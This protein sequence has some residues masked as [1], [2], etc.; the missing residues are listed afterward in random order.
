MRYRR[1]DAKL[2]TVAI[3][4][5]VVV[6]MFAQSDPAGWLAPILGNATAAGILAA[7]VLYLGPRAISEWKAQHDQLI[8]GFFGNEKH[9]G[10]IGRLTAEMAEEREQCAK[11]FQSMLTTVISQQEILR[12]QSDRLMEIERVM[13]IRKEL[14]GSGGPKGA[15]NPGGGR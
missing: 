3:A 12:Q 1:G 5:S 15:A 14:L 13:Q 8:V 6:G 9:P 11:N 4:G 2:A 7:V 10:A